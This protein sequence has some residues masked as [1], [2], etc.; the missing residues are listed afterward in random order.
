MDDHAGEQDDTFWKENRPAPLNHRES[1]TYAVLDSIGKEYHFDRLLSAM[2]SLGK[3][4]TS[5]SV[6]DLDIARFAS[7]NKYEGI[8]LGLGA[9]TNDKLIRNFSVGG[10]FGYGFKDERMKYGGEATLSLDKAKDW[11][12]SLR[13]QFDLRETGKTALNY[14]NPKEFNFR[15]YIA[16]Q[17]D[18]IQQSSGSL[19][20]R[21]LRY[22]RVNIL[23]Q[24][25]RVDPQYAYHFVSPETNSL[26]RYT[27]TDLAIN[28][29]Y[30]YKEKMI[31]SL[32]QRISMGTKYPV[33]SL[34]YSRGL[35]WFNGQFNY[36]KYEAR[37]E[38]T[39]YFRNLGESKIRLNAGYVDK[40]LP[41]GLLFTG[42]GSF[43][44]NFSVLVKNSFQ[45]IEPYQFLSDQYF[46]IH[47][48]HNFNSLLFHLG[49]WRPFIT[50]HQNLGWGSLAHPEYHQDIEFQTR[51]KGLYETGIQF[52][53]LLRFKYLNV[54][55]MGFGAGVFVRYGPYAIGQFSE[56]VAFTFSMTFTT[57]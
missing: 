49:N 56:D 21:T 10:Y 37:L 7:Y 11:Q 45:T 3:N 44:R 8:R 17:M 43:I 35:D 32:G 14:F 31:E 20:L 38:Q 15:N 16:S 39:I 1:T 12:I 54:S 25:T 47:Y 26:T 28:V 5:I 48:S 22:A 30:A 4:R 52:D 34:S 40:P 9:Y 53:N 24:N 18:R 19:S 6:I 13:H 55:Y 51:E 50:L 29:R 57:K 33:L 27:N 42:D 41:Y 36:N 2:E 46:S 23:L